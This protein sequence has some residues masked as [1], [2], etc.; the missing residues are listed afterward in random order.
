[1]LSKIIWAGRSR[2][3]KASGDCACRESGRGRGANR[4]GIRGEIIE[5]ADRKRRRST[6]EL[7]ED[8]R[9]LHAHRTRP[10]SGVTALASTDQLPGETVPCPVRTKPPGGCTGVEP[11]VS[12]VEPVVW[13]VVVLVAKGSLAQDTSINTKTETDKPS[14]IALFMM[15]YSFLFANL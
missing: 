1:M 11:V 6:A 7:H 12:G 8:N 10:C 3:R 15:H 13:R 4:G 5:L 14:M 9:V 2:R